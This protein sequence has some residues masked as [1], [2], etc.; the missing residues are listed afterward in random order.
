MTALQKFIASATVIVLA[1]T[2]TYYA[3]QA[4]NTFKSS[5][6]SAPPGTEAVAPAKSP[7][8]STEFAREVAPEVQSLLA[9]LQSSNPETRLHAIKAIGNLGPKGAVA[10][11]MLRRLDDQERSVRV[12]T[13]HALG[14]IGPAASLAFPALRKQARL[15]SAAEQSMANRAIRKIEN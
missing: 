5:S 14:K 13:A 7:T 1:G 4:Q 2:G 6:S 9:K 3:R 12:L 15:G 11:P 8:G 10:V